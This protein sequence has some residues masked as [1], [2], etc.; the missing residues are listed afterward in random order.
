MLRIT[1]NVISREV[2][3]LAKVPEFRSAWDLNSREMGGSPELGGQRSV[4]GELRDFVL[5]TR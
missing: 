4:I 1:E 3:R 5:K 2:G